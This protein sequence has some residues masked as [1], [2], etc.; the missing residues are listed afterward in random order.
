VSVVSFQIKIK[1]SAARELAAAEIAI[2]MKLT[3]A[4]KLGTTSGGTKIIVIR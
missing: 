3:Q 4:R 2:S 1:R